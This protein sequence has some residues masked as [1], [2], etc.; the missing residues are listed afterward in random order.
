MSKSTITKKKAY[1]H[2][3]II[4]ILSLML[5]V[6][7]YALVLSLVSVDGNLFETGRIEIELNG[8]KTV[9]DGSD[10]NLAPGISTEKSFT[11]QNTGTADVYY[12]IYLENVAGPLQEVLEFKIYDND[13]L[14]YSGAA[15]DLNKNTPCIGDRS[16][17]V[18]QTH[19]LKAVVTMSEQ[20]DNNYQLQEI[21]FDITA[22]AIQVKNN[23][24][25]VFE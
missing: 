21:T 9:F 4:S 19:T 1:G 23:S 18:G 3:L 25:K 6:T 16:L 22:D 2:I 20:A 5:I 8:G 12:R 14:L 10:I 7:T 24:Q 13:K 11:I 17:E 15:K